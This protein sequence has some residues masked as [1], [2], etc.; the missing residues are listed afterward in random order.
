MFTLQNEVYGP[1]DT[2]R[3]EPPAGGLCISIIG[4]SVSDSKT[5]TLSAFLPC[6]KKGYALSRKFPSSANL[7][8]CR[9]ARSIFKQ[10][11][12]AMTTVFLFSPI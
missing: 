6:Q 2:I 4:S 5:Y 10:D 3:S 7:V 12:T 11:N 8:S 9:A 1:K